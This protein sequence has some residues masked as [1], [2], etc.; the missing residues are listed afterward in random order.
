MFAADTAEGL[1]SS[2]QQL[3]FVVA[4]GFRHVVSSSGQHLAHDIGI[5]RGRKQENREL[6]ISLTDLREKIDDISIQ[7]W[8]NDQTVWLLRVVGAQSCLSRSAVS[9]ENS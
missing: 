8:L 6:R 9:T 1:N 5:L 4:V 3:G 7:R 2:G